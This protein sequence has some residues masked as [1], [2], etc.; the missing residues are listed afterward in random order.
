MSRRLFREGLP[1]ANTVTKPK[2]EHTDEEEGEVEQKAAS[3]NRY[4]NISRSALLL[5]DALTRF[6][7]DL[8]ITEIA[9][10]S[11]L[12]SC[13]LQGFGYPK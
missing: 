9:L 5:L 6:F 8:S 11:S 3:V 10:H 13:P 2:A 7:L 12:S 4:F 1:N